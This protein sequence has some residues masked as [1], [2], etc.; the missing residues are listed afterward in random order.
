MKTGL[1]YQI[2]KAIIFY[3]LFVITIKLAV[4]YGVRE[5][6]F[7]EKSWDVLFGGGLGLVAG[8]AFFAIFGG[9]GL[10]S[11]G[12]YGAL[13]LLGLAVFG[14]TIGLGF[15][16]IVNIIRS[17][18]SYVFDWQTIIVV[19][20]L[21][22]LFARASAIGLARLFFGEARISITGVAERPPDSP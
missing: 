13:D 14:G 5:K 11:G 16:G 2:T 17:P 7:L 1:G 22:T 21:G 3:G 10:V 20:I 6:T 4:A 12:I 9:V 18:D 15:G 8:I 19:M